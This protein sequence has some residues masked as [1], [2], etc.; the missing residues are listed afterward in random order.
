MRCRRMM[1]A[2]VALAAAMICLSAK[3]DWPN[4]NPTKWV[5]LPDESPLGLDV[6]ASVPHTLADDLV[7]CNIPGTR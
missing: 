2:C 4:N 3:A 5:Q 6:N 7:R 1:L